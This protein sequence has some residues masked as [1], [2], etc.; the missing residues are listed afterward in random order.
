[1]VSKSKSKQAQKQ[2]QNVKVVINQNDNKKQRN[3]SKKREQR[4]KQTQSGQPVIPRPYAYTPE[5]G[6]RRYQTFAP[7]ISNNTAPDF[8]GVINALRASIMGTVRQPISNET[9]TTKTPLKE[10]IEIKRQSIAL[11]AIDSPRTVFGTRK[12]PAKVDKIQQTQTDA[13]IDL[14]NQPFIY[15]NDYKPPQPVRFQEP[16]ENDIMPS[17]D[18]DSVSLLG[19]VE[20]SV[21]PSNVKDIKS[22]SLQK[23]LNTPSKNLQGGYVFG[24]IASGRA[25]SS[26]LIRSKSPEEKIDMS[27][28]MV[29]YK[30]F[31][32]SPS[33]EIPESHS[34][35][36]RK[37]LSSYEEAGMD[38]RLP[39]N[40]RQD[41][42][43]ASS[44]VYDDDNLMEIAEL[45]GA[46]TNA[47]EEETMPS[48]RPSPSNITN[49]MPRITRSG[50]PDKWFLE[51]RETTL[52]L[53]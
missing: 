20:S 40:P 15:N 24:D 51:N 36:L 18:D 7:Q 45:Q 23:I 34:Q 12:T 42:N 3:R 8:N 48:V 37:S 31:P 26:D 33:Y 17:Y 46:K 10:P 43:I 5:Q 32:I 35:K 41:Y 49:R 16:T 14:T 29:P 25:F 47:K 21:Q 9:N 6:M 28:G 19:T 52:N 50:K 39:N 2:E 38:F 22:Y 30:G 11:D 44:L 27:S 53:L 13:Y 1:M 4:T